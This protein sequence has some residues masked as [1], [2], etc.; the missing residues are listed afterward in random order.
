MAGRPYTK[1]Y[2]VHERV[3]WADFKA[4]AIILP[5]LI[6]ILLVHSWGTR[7][8]RRKAAAWINAH[9]AALRAEFASVGFE[10]R[11]GLSADAA[12][13]GG[14]ANDDDKTEVMREK[15]K[16]VFLSYATGRQ[17]V[18]FVDIKL[19]LYKRYN[20]FAFIGDFGLAFFMDSMPAPT[21][22]VEIT[23]YAFDGKEG[24]FIPRIPSAAEPERRGR[25]STYDGFVWAVVHKD[26]MQRLRDERYDVSLTTTR[27]HAKLPAWA[28]IMSESAEITETLLTPELVKAVEAAGEDFGSLIVTDLPEDQPK[29]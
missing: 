15:S 23:A 28:S 7:T 11:K 22:K 14:L 5:V 12:Q 20:P 18:A 3:T 10:G 8:N 16:D 27:D 13:Q 29:T 4:E 9:K 1:W 26:E 21:E 17:N 2:N 19:S 6:I 24:Q 25:D